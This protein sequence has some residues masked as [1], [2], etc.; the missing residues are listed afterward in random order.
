VHFTPE[1]PKPHTI[2][3]REAY[4]SSMLQ[5]WGIINVLRDV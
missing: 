2:D 5:V 4:D 1:Y 3:I